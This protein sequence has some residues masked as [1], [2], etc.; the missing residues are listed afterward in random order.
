MSNIWKR[1]LSFFLAAAMVFGMLPMP[2][3]AAED[4]GFDSLEEVFEDERFVENMEFEETEHSDEESEWESDEDA[5]EES[6]DFEDSDLEDLE[7]EEDTLTLSGDTRKIYF[8]NAESWETV[9]AAW[10]F[11]EEDFEDETFPGVELT[12]DEVLENAY[13][14]ELPVEA[15]EVCFS[16]G[17][18]LTEELLA[19]EADAGLK[20]THQ[21]TVAL[22]KALDCYDNGWVSYD[23]LV[24]APV[25]ALIDALPAEVNSDAE[26]EAVWAAIEAI[27]GEMAELTEEQQALLDMTGYNTAMDAAA[28]FFNPE[29]PTTWEA[30][31]PA[32]E[33]DEPEAQAAGYDPAWRNNEFGVIEVYNDASTVTKSQLFKLLDNHLETQALSLAG[34]GVGGFKYNGTQIKGSTEPGY[35]GLTTG[36]TYNVQRCTKA[37]INWQLQENSTW[38]DAGSFTVEVYDILTVNNSGSAEEIKVFR[39]TGYDLV[40]PEREGYTVK[41]TG[42]VT[43]DAPGTYHIDLTADAEVNVEYINATVKSNVYLTVNGGEYGTAYMVNK[44]GQ[45]IAD[46]TELPEGTDI[47]VVTEVK[48]SNDTAV[49]Y[50]LAEISARDFR[51]GTEDTTVTVT[52]AKEELILN[53]E[54]YVIEI[55]GFNTESAAEGLKG[56]VLD[57]VIDGAYNPDDYKVEMLT[58]YKLGSWELGEAYYDVTGYDGQYID[59]PASWFISQIKVD[60]VTENNFKITKLAKSNDSGKNLYKEDVMVIADD[61]RDPAE[62]RLIEKSFNVDELSEAAALVKA[63]VQYKKDGAWVDITDSHVTVSAIANEGKQ[64][65]TI[66]VTSDSEDYQKNETGITEEITVTLNGYTVTWI[67]GTERTTDTYKY[68]QTIVKPA[69]PTAP[70]GHSFAGWD[71]EV[72]ATMGKTDLTYTAVF[73]PNTYKVTW[74]VDGEAYGEPTE[75]TYGKA[76][77]APEYTVPAGYT[78]SGWTVPEKMPAEDITLNATLTPISYEVKWV[79]QNA[80]G[81]QATTQTLPYGT[82]VVVPSEIPAQYTVGNVTYTRT[83]WTPELK[84]DATVPVGGI[85]YTATYTE[86][87]AWIVTFDTDGG[88]NINPVTVIVPEGETNVVVK[89]EVV[90]T[91]AG[92][93]FVGWYLDGAEYNFDAPVTGDITLTAKWVKLVTVTFEGAEGEAYAPQTVDIGGKA[94]KPADPT[95]AGYRFDGWYLGETKYDFNY[96]VTENITL[97]AKWLNDANRN[98]VEDEKEIVSIKVT[99]E[100]EIPLSE[101][102][103]EMPISTED[104]KSYIFDSTKPSITITATP[105]V[106][107][108]EIEGEA[109]P[110]STTYV[111]SIG[112][113][114]LTY[115]DNFVATAELTVA[116]GDEITVTFEKATFTY[117]EDGQMRFYVGM[118]DPDYETLYNAVIKTPKYDA[119][120]GV[121]TAKYL[122]RPAAT[123]QMQ[124]PVLAEI[125]LP[126]WANGLGID[127]IVIG[128]NVVDIDLDDAWLDVGESFKTLTPE[129]LQKQYDEEIQKIKDKV[130]A[131]DLSDLSLSNAWDKVKEIWAISDELSVLIDTIKNEAEYLGYHQFGASALKDENGNAQELLQVIYQNEVMRLVNEELYVTLVD[132]RI[133]T[134]ITAGDLTFEYDE[135]TD[136]DIM[137]ALV[138][139]DVNGNAVEGQLVKHVDLVGTEV[140]SRTFSVSYAGSWDHK[141]CT[142]EFTLTVVKAPSA[143]D[144]LNQN[145]PYGTTVSAPVIT[146]KHGNAIDIEAIQFILGLDVA[147]LD[148]DSDGVKGLEGK[149]QLILPES[150]QGILALIGLEE[151]ATLN[152][153]DLI[154]LLTNELLSGVLGE[155]GITSEL[156]D[157][158]DGILQTIN[159]ITETNNLEI[160]IGG[161]YPTDIGAYLHG[162]VTVDGNYETAFDVGYI[163]INPVAERVYL[164]WN[165]DAPNG[166]FTPALLETMNLSATAYAEETF[167]TKVAAATELIN[168]LFFG[169]DA[170]GEFVAELFNKEITD[171]EELENKL[172]NGAYAQMAFVAEFGNE[173]YYSVPIV[174]AFVLIPD[175]FEVRLV[176]ETGTANRELLKTFNNEPQGFSVK[177]TDQNGK[178]IY[179]DHYQTSDV[180]E[181]QNPVITYNYVGIQTNGQTYQSSEKPVHAGAYA[182]TV[183]VEDRDNDGNLLGFGADVGLLIIE[184]AESDVMVEDKIVKNETVKFRD[185]VTATSTGTKLTPDTTII[186]A[187]IDTNED[188]NEAGWDAVNGVV[189][190]DFP[191]W[192]DALLAEYAPS[193]QNGITASQ[194]KDKLENKLPDISEKLTELGATKEVINSLANL[195]EN[196]NKV[197]AEMPANITLSFNDDAKANEI[198][199]Y[200]VTAIVTDSDHYPSADAGYL[201]VLPEVS[202]VELKWNYEDENGIF[203]RDLLE[204]VDLLAKAY[205]VNNGEEVEANITYQFIGINSDNEPVIYTDPAT[206]PNGAYVEVAYVELYIDGQ[207]VI[208]DMIARPVVI[209]ASNCN[210]KI[211]NVETV[212]SNEA[213]EIIVEVTDLNGKKINTAN[214][215]LTV[216]YAGL[217]TNG[218]PYASTEAPVHAG[219]YEALV[220]YIEYVD[221]ELRYYGANAGYVLIDLAASEIDVTGDTVT[222]DGKGHTAKVE[223][224]KGHPYADYTL[225]SGGVSISGDVEKAGVDAFRGNVNIDLPRWLNEALDKYEFTDGID[226]A[227]LADYMDVYRNDLIKAVTVDK[228]VEWKVITE[229]QQNAYV[230]KLNAYIDELIAVLKQMPKDVKLTFVDGITYTEPGAYCYYGIVTDSDHYPS[231]DTGLLVIE[232][233]DVTVTMDDLS[234]VYGTENDPELT[235]TV[236][237]LVSGDK[238]TVVASREKGENVGEYK[239]TAEASHPFYSVTVLPGTFTITKAPVTVKVDNKFKV[240]GQDDPEFTATVTGLAGEDTLDI[241]F[242]RET[243]ENVGT[244]IIKASAEDENYKITVEFGELVI[245][246]APVIVTV[247]NQTKVYGEKDPE[248]TVT[249]GKLQFNDKLDIVITR[250]SG[251]DVGEYTIK[252]DVKNENYDIT[253]NFGKLTITAK[254]LTDENVT[255]A[256]DLTYSG[257]EQTQKIVVKDGDKVLVEGKDYKVEGNTETNAGNYTMTITGIGNYAGSIEQAWSIAKKAVTVAAKAATKVYGDAEPAYECTFDGL[258]EDDKLIVS[259]NREQGEDVGTYE[260]TPVVNAESE[261]YGNYNITYATSTLTITPAELTVNVTKAEKFYGEGDEEIVYEFAVTGYKLSDNENTVPVTV[262]RDPESKGENAGDAYKLTAS[263]DSKNYTVKAEGANLTIKKAAFYV[264]A[265]DK[266][267]VLDVEIPALDFSI[268]E[269]QSK[270]KLREGDKL[271]VKLITNPAKNSVG[272]YIVGEYPIVDNETVKECEN[273]IIKEVKAGK[274]TV[275][276]GDYVCWNTKTSKYYSTIT[277]GLMEAVSGEEVQVLVDVTT[278]ESVLLVRPGITLDLNGHKVHAD[279]VISTFVEAEIIDSQNGAALLVADMNQVQMDEANDQLPVWNGQNGYVFTEVNVNKNQVV[280]VPQNGSA[281]SEYVTLPIFNNT[282]KELL[283]DGAE[284]NNISIVARVKWGGEET[285]IVQH[286]VFNDDIIEQVYG[287]R[288]NFSLTLRNAFDLENAEYYIAI[289]SGTDAEIESSGKSVQY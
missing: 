129:E 30:V 65:I 259:Y 130:A 66:T 114:E 134:T 199:A 19:A 63:A 72:A 59:I 98:G 221:G 207:M 96:E 69:D 131:I 163:L 25:Q 21:I 28:A 95:K 75:V 153:N 189:N 198:G 217:Q 248:L 29:E 49:A 122:A 4:D 181:L 80:E 33:E 262:A 54:P 174:R 281:G 225:I 119:T 34:I 103:I 27:D 40:V 78:F 48:S 149:M 252:A 219:V 2:S 242:D 245:T 223:I 22:D 57:A 157:A 250:E 107:E 257:E 184:P 24:V 91:K 120:E 154:E 17:L 265:N 46:G 283:K 176:G 12:E 94:K 238:L 208:S 36:V 169:F 185:L 233:A 205:D 251:E 220:T 93:R 272:Q 50:Y 213:H 209:V 158:L 142:A 127:D 151:G 71:S 156:I 177:V 159:G 192:L 194:L 183:S 226:A 271:D 214:G 249:V 105:V 20:V 195:T 11:E 267:M 90:P 109:K 141:P 147:D 197:L 173:F 97:T 182:V 8:F 18:E 287:N 148:I 240:Y 118:E 5:W 190:I 289:V 172:S 61:S 102:L 82:A 239:I 284:D 196:I 258:V 270:G 276:L 6:E 116:N 232:K 111:A 117:D 70:T 266:S 277:G 203:T 74:T 10:S 247:D 83:G 170:N 274:L 179:S 263:V 228:L 246:K 164:D 212:F 86:A 3:Y 175:V 101:G 43:A 45:Q 87:T 206:V 150:L 286:F 260:I 143:V 64:S 7:E 123:Y 180:N 67:V 279:F 89:P 187:G 227:K 41:I 56:F 285:E 113:E 124:V 37:S 231:T 275:E 166:V 121:I 76:I 115:G 58:E 38:A 241:A 178:L 32:A 42:A 229:E 31:E 268:D 14:L 167:E 108:V 99:G 269:T 216:L 168:N 88:S 53:E 16:D 128:G 125:D 234:K 51:V 210:V 201:V 278:A 200:I 202:Q 155:W 273:W 161:T 146:N 104:T 81:E 230:E 68:G 236:D 84:N 126:G 253:L 85:T 136:A 152:L 218:K 224:T 145:I 106:T 186:T 244:Y 237:G 138:L 39:G 92:Y 133:E 193:V 132:D 44:E 35:A 191:E 60:G 62:I 23:A 9:W 144:V 261:D 211:E 255:L 188:I 256:G 15:D 282:V 47:T 165:F 100:G 26:C 254:A 137:N 264:V 110:V 204:E 79:W 215:E 235:Y 1:S 171:P 280:R 139:T 73:T 222:Y 162:A 112:S 140:G 13:V 55:N 135:F 243:G 160:T 52:F 77:T 288:K